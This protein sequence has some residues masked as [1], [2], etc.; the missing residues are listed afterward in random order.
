QTL[1]AGRKPENPNVY[2]VREGESGV[3]PTVLPPGLYY[4]NPFEK[5]IDVIDIRSHTLDLRGNEVIEFP[6]NDSFAI[7]IEA[8][9]EYAIRQEKAPYVLVAIGEHP[10]VGNRIILPYMNSL[11]RIEG[12]KLFARDFIAGETRTAFQNRVFDQ[13]R[14]NCYD[15]GIEIRA[16]LIRKIVAPDAI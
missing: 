3:Q 14:K 12:S 10:Q 2:V 8:T 7:Q 6:S 16:A 1:L 9:V 13:L 5:R 4:N 11:A 15:Q